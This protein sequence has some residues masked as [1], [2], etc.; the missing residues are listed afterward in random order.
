MTKKVSYEA[1]TVR[2]YLHDENGPAWQYMKTFV[3]PVPYYAVRSVKN[4]TWRNIK[5]PMSLRRAEEHLS[6]KKTY[7]CL[8]R[9]YPF[10]C[11]L[12]IDGWD[13]PQVEDFRSTVNMTENNSM[14]FYGEK[15]DHWRLLFRPTYKRKPPTIKL[16]QMAMKGVA[17]KYGVEI[18]PQ[19]KKISRLPFSAQYTPGDYDNWLLDNTALLRAFERL[20]TYDITNDCPVPAPVQDQQ[21]WLFTEE[22][23]KKSGWYAEGNFLYESGLIETNS[24][25]LAQR[26][27]IYYLYRQNTPKD[28]AEQLARNWIKTKN[29]GKS[30]DWFNDRS[31][32]YKEIKSAID[33]FYDSAFEEDYFPDSTNIVFNG[34]LSKVDLIEIVRISG[35]NLPRSRFLSHLIQYANPRREQRSIRIHSEEKLIE[36]G[37]TENYLLFLNELKRKGVVKRKEGRTGYLVNSY[38]KPMKIYWNWTPATKAVLTDNRPPETF[39]ETVKI[40]FD[41]PRDYSAL[42]RSAR[43]TKQAIY[44]QTKNIFTKR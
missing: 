30:Y 40:A 23:K 35:G 6:G 25:N 39:D 9:W 22:M 8:A 16:L 13:S 10:H 19:A 5:A 15:K 17:N 27:V 36:W 3:Q 11:D 18:Y 31:R 29:N 7:G 33:Y 21:E 28:F 43:L 41:N 32:V 44:G 38:S 4:N 34:W 26:K 2:N 12:D 42:L 37:S 20:D 1:H 14:L 24:R